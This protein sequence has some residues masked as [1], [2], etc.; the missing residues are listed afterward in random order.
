MPAA[1]TRFASAAALRKRQPN[2]RTRLCLDPGRRRASDALSPG[3]GDQTADGGPSRSAVL[4]R[5]S[6]QRPEQLYAA[7][8]HEGDDDRPRRGCPRRLRGVHPLGRLQ[9][10]PASAGDRGG[11][12]RLRDG[13]I[14]EPGATWQYKAEEEVVT[15]VTRIDGTVV[16]CAYIPSGASTSDRI[17]QTASDFEGLICDGK[18]PISG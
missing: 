9:E 4:A 13:R 12:R 1:S 8:W 7:A 11:V 2:R 3:R 14:V 17:Q 5:G 6:R 10:R 16:G 15:K 18:R